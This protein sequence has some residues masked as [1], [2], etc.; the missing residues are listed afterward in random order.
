MGFPA[1][2]DNNKEYW[3]KRV[4]L[5]FPEAIRFDGFFLRF[6]KGKTPAKNG[7][8]QEIDYFTYIVI[9]KIILIYI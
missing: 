4:K 3:K 7:T 9:R 6:L 2:F 1:I 5:F 8:I